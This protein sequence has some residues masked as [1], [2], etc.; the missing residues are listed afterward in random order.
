ML[1]GDAWHYM[2][3]VQNSRAYATAWFTMVKALGVNY[4]RLHAM[5]YP[6]VY[7]DVADELGLLIVAES[8]VY[9]SSGNYA[10]TSED[11]LANCAEHLT[12]R[13]LR[14]RNHPSVFAW[15]AENEMLAAFGQSWAAKVSALKP[16]VTALDTTR[17]VYFEGDGDPVSSGDLESTHY[18]LEITTGS[19]RSRSP[20]TCWH[21]ASPGRTS[22][23]AR[24]RC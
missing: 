13:V 9:G 1:R 20:R 15:A 7:Y 23:T 19:T 10:L 22:G 2:G 16:A 4:L 21:P 6:S 8:G 12:A 5:P 18:P 14:D 17:P 11:F 3:S 24:N